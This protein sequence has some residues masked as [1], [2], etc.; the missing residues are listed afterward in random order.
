MLLAIT[1]VARLT[2]STLACAIATFL[3]PLRRGLSPMLPRTCE[4]FLYTLALSFP[5]S[6]PVD[7]V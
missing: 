2:L 3:F 7:G 5:L 4:L 6:D 1:G